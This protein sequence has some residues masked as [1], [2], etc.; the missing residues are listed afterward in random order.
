[1][2]ESTL[3]LGL[4]ALRAEVA[5][6]LGKGR[7]SDN[8][9]DEDI[10]IFDAHIR[11]GLRMFYNPLGHVWSFFKPFLSLPLSS[12]TASYALP[13]DF[14]FAIGDIVLTDGA[15]SRKWILR[16][17]PAQRM[18]A[19]PAKAGKPMY[20]A[21]TPVAPDEESGNGQRYQISV[22]PTPN[23]DYTLTVQYS[24][25]PHMISVLN[26]Y[27]YGGEPHA[28]TIREAVLSKAEADTEDGSIGVHTQN[29]QERLAASI[30]YDKNLSAPDN[31]GYNGD[32]RRGVFLKRGIDMYVHGVSL[33]AFGEN[34]DQWV[35]EE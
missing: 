28:E 20:Y 15:S 5:Y 8:W 2:S 11:A 17:V 4:D 21:I 1:M 35:V 22:Y 3:S 24:V 33:N 7:D 19:C 6:F 9:T 29:Y 16:Q 34:I 10:A 27:P 13:D 32:G 25:V 18:N 26:P 23:A 12:G 30:A 14:G 31:L